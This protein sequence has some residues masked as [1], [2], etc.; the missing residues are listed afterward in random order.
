MD[1]KRPDPHDFKPKVILHGG[2]GSITRGKLPPELY[3]LYEHSLLGYLKTTKRQL[4]SGSSALDAVVHAVSLMEDDE[5]F[6]CG[7]GSVFNLKGE[8]EME[9]SV[10]VASLVDD[11]GAVRGLKKRAAAVS[12]VRETRHPIRL[13]R[14][15]LLQG[16][17]ADGVRDMHCH[18]SG[19][20]V[21][22]WGWTKGL[23]RKDQ[24]WFWTKRRW[25]EHLRGLGKDHELDGGIETLP[26]QGTVG[27]VCSDRYGNVAVATSTGGLTNKLP[28][29]IGDTPTVGAGFWAERWEED[30][31]RNASEERSA[32]S[33]SGDVL[34]DMFNAC[35]LPALAS[36]IVPIYSRFFRPPMSPSY[37]QLQPTK[38]GYLH[39]TQPI[40]PGDAVGR[41]A[42]ALS[43]TGNGDSFLRTAAARSAAARCRYSSPHV[44][45]QCAVSAVAGPGGELERS[46]GE[47]FG[48]TGEGEGGFIGIEL[49]SNGGATTVFDFNCGG[50][51]RAYYVGEGDSERPTVMVFRE[52]YK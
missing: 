38:E 35:L 26:S 44:T 28:G 45:L 14:A 18:L 9:A 24:D 33:T 29:R 7:R 41:R 23:E 36:S 13:A 11:D 22:E 52:E 4:D 15:V 8:I 1:Y 49:D 10:M 30:Q 5:L 37:L 31:D 6:N 47:R 21:E 16:D 48:H 12:M 51:W 46:A 20:E 25:L 3:A 17:E 27:A 42:V 43:G 34:T 32:D 40:S 50:M 19:R 39:G 2:A